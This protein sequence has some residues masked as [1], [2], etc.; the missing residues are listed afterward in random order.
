MKPLAR[1]AGLMS[2][3]GLLAVPAHAAAVRHGYAYQSGY[4]VRTPSGYRWVPRTQVRS[5]YSVPSAYSNRWTRMR[6]EQRL[7]REQLRAQQYQ[8][9]RAQ[10]YQQLRAQRYQQLRAQ[11]YQQL[12]ARERYYR[13]RR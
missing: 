3:V 6:A 8:Q 7:E 2:I 4:Y 13:Y 10:R 12:R 1:L 5:T 9:L 11:R